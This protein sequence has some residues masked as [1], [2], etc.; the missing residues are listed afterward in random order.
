[1]CISCQSSLNWAGSHGG[2]VGQESGF[3][4][5]HCRSA[6]F[7]CKVGH[8]LR[9]TALKGQRRGFVPHTPDISRK[10]ASAT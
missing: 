7:P 2:Y 6:E 3:K 10:V 5:G 9:E 8:G 1:M 4:K